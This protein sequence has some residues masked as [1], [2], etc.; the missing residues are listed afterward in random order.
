MGGKKTVEEK[1]TQKDGR[2]ARAETTAGEEK[3]GL[4]EQIEVVGRRDYILRPRYCAL[5]LRIVGN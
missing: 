4:R 2:K 3:R 5:F 1:R